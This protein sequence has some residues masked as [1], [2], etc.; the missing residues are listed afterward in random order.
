M[1]KIQRRLEGMIRGNTKIMSAVLIAAMTV[2]AMTPLM[3]A[4]KEEHGTAADASDSAS[5]EET[6]DDAAGASS[7]EASDAPA[8]TSQEETEAA[9]PAASRTIKTNLLESFNTGFEGAD[10]SGNVYWW[11]DSAWKQV[12]TVRTAYQDSG[13]AKPSA[14]SG[15]YYLT[16]SP[17]SETKQ[18]QAQL[19]S[20]DIAKLMKAGKTYEYT[21]YVRLA[22]GETEGKVTLAVN[23]ISSDWSTVKSATVVQDQEQQLS[24]RE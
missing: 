3:T 8:G 16:V 6:A 21:C 22:K 19:C 13:I 12:H 5:S 24:D 9:A 17:E 15:D 14:D 11:N 1:Q 20:A 23:S 7:S 18:A 2:T 10:G 4:A